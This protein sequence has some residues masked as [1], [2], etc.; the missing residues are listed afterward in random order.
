M[1]P[2]T[3]VTALSLICRCGNTHEAVP[4]SP[5][6]P[7]PPSHPSDKPNRLL[8]STP[9]GAHYSMPISLT[10]ASNQLMFERPP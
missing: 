8:L 1:W 9:G 3:N 5:I 7:P 6:H 4:Q 10:A 2:T